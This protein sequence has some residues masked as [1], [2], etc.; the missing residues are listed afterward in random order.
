MARRLASLVLL[1]PIV[2]RSGPSSREGTDTGPFSARQLKLRSPRLQLRR[3]P[4]A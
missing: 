3:P 4:R 1:V 2:Q